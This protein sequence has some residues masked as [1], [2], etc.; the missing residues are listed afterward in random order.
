MT[1]QIPYMHVK[2]NALDCI[3]SVEVQDNKTL[4]VK[5]MAMGAIQE[6]IRQGKIFYRAYTVKDVDY[7]LR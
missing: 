2:N 4:N 3:I 6:F 1:S 5:I 7:I